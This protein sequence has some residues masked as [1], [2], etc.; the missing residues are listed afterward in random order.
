MPASNIRFRRS[1]W[2]SPLTLLL[3]APSLPAAAERRSSTAYPL[4]APV[5]GRRLAKTAAQG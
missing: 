5:K 2:S 3:L 4:I 1:T